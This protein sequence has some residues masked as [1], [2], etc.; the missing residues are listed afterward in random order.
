MIGT[1]IITVSTPASVR[2]ARKVRS[3]IEPNDTGSRC[4]PRPRDSK[5]SYTPWSAGSTPVRNEG[6][7][8]QEWVGSVDRSVARP[9]RDTR[10]ARLG[11]TPDSISGSR[12]RQSA[13][14]QPISKTRV[15]SFPGCRGAA[16][17]VDRGSS[18]E[19]ARGE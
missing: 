15:I 11:R 10:A 5:M 9:P 7:A 2:S 13:P 8:V 3:L 19:V 18:L 16:G 17:S 12:I 6:H 1:F 14:S 4:A